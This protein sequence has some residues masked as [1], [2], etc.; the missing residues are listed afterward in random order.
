MPTAE[1]LIQK[2]EGKLDTQDTLIWPGGNSQEKP[3]TNKSFLRLYSHNMCPFAERAR[4]A[5][6]AKQIPFQEVFVD[7]SDKAQWHVDFNKG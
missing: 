3:E 7:L 1:V 4:L 5:L 2:S 6:A